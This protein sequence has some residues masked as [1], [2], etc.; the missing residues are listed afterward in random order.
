[1]KRLKRILKIT[2]INVIVFV[3]LLELIA[4]AIYF[5]NHK[6]FFYTDKHRYEGEQS[7]RESIAPNLD[8]QLTDERFHPFFGYTHKA[9]LKNTNNYGFHCSHD[10]PL[11]KEKGNWYIIGIFGG[12]VAN[13][14]YEKGREQLTKKL[15]AHPRFA[16]KE[17]VY[18]N[19][20]LGGY[21]QPQQLHILTYFLAI[22]QQL[23]IVINIDGFNEMIFCFNNNRLNVD[24]AMPSAQHFLPMRDLMDSR[25]VTGERLESMWNIQNYKKDYIRVKEKLRTT[26]LASVYL[27]YSIYGKHV[28]KKY[29]SEI[30]RFDNLIKPAKPEPED[31]IANIKYTPA[32]TN[33]SALMAK[34]ATLY[35]RTSFT[36]H[37]AATAWGGQYF[38]FLQPNQY[39]AKKPFTKKEQETALDQGLTYNF[40]VKKGYPVLH[41]VIEA[42]KKNQVNAFSAAAIFDNVKE[43]VFIDKCCHFNRYGNEIFAD[44]IAGCILKNYAFS[45]RRGAA[46]PAYKDAKE[47]EDKK[48]RR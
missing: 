16:D 42:L 45:P 24:L 36:M 5:F 27:I 19:Y 6:T 9:G 17:V 18:L 3:V 39:Y 47:R 41:R 40:L 29:R 14:F 35:Y 11:K 22:G 7:T 44:F 8:A 28:Y 32:I 23:D 31:S 2:A 21:K 10:Y 15:K 48:R 26:K 12:S 13:D 34:V 37:S 30:V 1:M 33:E 46:H 43:T 4:A 38:H 20:A 25:T